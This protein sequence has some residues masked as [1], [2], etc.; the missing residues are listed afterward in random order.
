MLKY[1]TL[2]KLGLNKLFWLNLGD[3]TKLCWI[4]LLKFNYATLVELG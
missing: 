1:V 4:G 2:V 3:G